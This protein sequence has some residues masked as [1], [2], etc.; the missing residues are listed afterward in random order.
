ML[1]RYRYRGNN[2]DVPLWMVVEWGMV[3][4]GSTFSLYDS[5]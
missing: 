3:E 1:V 5:E 2:I 4:G